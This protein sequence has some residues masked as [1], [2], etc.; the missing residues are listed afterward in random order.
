MAPPILRRRRRGLAAAAWTPLTPA[1]LRAWWSP[2]GKFNATPTALLDSEDLVTWVDAKGNYDADEIGTDNPTGVTSGAGVAVAFN[3]GQSIGMTPTALPADT[4]GTV[5]FIVRTGTL[6]QFDTPICFSD[7]SGANKQFLFC[8]HNSSGYRWSVYVQNGVGNNRQWSGDTTLSNTTWYDVIYQ[9]TG[10]DLLMW[11]NGTAQTV[12]Q[13]STGGTPL[14]IGQWL[15]ANSM[16]CV[17]LG[18][19]RWSSGYAEYWPGRADQYWWY[20]SVLTGTDLTNLQAYLAARRA[21]L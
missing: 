14:T 17:H 16:D 6:A 10:S 4:A 19:R 18:A 9:F 2:D 5:A 7:T 8:T 12:S 1:S 15:S 3:G 13:I 21:L 20:S 11:V